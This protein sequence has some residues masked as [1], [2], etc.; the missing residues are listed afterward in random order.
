MRIVKVEF[1]DKI[2]QLSHQE[3]KWQILYIKGT[4]PTIA[5]VNESPVVGSNG[6]FFYGARTDVRE[7]VIGLKINSDVEKHC[8][9]LYEYLSTP[10]KVR[11]Y[12]KTE[13]VDT[14]IDGIVTVNDCD[15]NVQN[16]IMQVTIRCSQSYFNDIKKIIID[17]SMREDLFEFKVDET[18]DDN[19]IGYFQINQEYENGAYTGGIAFTNIKSN[20]T[21]KL[22]NTGQV[23]L[24]LLIKIEC[25]EDVVNP[26]VTNLLDVNEFIGINYTLLKND[27]LYINTHF[28]EE[29]I[30]AIR[31]GEKINLLNYIVKNITWLQLKKGEQQY[32][33]TCDNSVENMLVSF[34]YTPQYKGV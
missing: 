8:L 6:S 16:V 20:N 29:E 24:G 4:N 17:A 27:I 2:L 32:V 28:G 14:Y 9:E 30:Y 23:P 7:L 25:I 26:T 1:E 31:N 21:A 33:C 11:F 34:E 19:T 5:Q 18:S 12:Y 3:R 15:T 10:N 13:R 22:N